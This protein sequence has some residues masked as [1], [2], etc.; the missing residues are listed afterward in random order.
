MLYTVFCEDG[1][2]VFREGSQKLR[3]NFTVKELADND[4]HTLVWKT[5]QGDLIQAIRDYLGHSVTVSSHYRTP[6]RNK[7]VGGSLHSDHQLGQATDLLLNPNGMKRTELIDLITFAVE[8]GAREIG[9]YTPGKN[10]IHV[11][12]VGWGTKK[13]QVDGIEFSL[14]VQGTDQYNLLEY[15]R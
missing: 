1:R 2:T 10:F 5:K 12:Y 4:S 15:F 8:N 7:E 3:D 14:Y 11:S 13:H 6:V 9:I